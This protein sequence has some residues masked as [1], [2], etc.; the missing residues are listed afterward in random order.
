MTLFKGSL[1]E[2][3][4]IESDSSLSQSPNM[5]DWLSQARSTRNQQHQDTVQR[6]RVDNQT[7][8]VSQ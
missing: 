7:T 1:Q 4:D 2:Q 8:T 3:E 6:Q 5:M